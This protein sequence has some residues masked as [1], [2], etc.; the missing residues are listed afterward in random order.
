MSAGELFDVFIVVL[1]GLA[2]SGNLAGE[3]VLGPALLGAGGL[4]AFL[5]NWLRIPRWKR[6]RA[7]QMKHLNAF[8]A[9]NAAGALAAADIHA[10]IPMPNADAA[11][12]TR[13]VRG[14]VPDVM[15]TRS[16][17]TGMPRRS[18]SAAT[19]SRVVAGMS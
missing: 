3:A 18:H 19:A 5:T 15:T 16:G 1:I 9:V 14:D 12:R 17:E 11:I 10:R 13:L 7:E 2:M 6:L 8:I 4:G